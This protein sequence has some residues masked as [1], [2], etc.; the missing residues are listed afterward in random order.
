MSHVCSYYI[1]NGIKK[2]KIPSQYLK[3]I[4][5][6]GKEGVE[7]G[8]EWVSSDKCNAEAERGFSLVNITKIIPDLWWSYIPIIHCWGF[9][10]GASGQE[11][12]WQCRRYMRHG[13]DPWRGK[14]PWSRK[15]HPTP[16][17]LPEKF[18]GQRSLVGYS[19]WG[20]KESDVTERQST[21]THH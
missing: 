11:P 4:I 17:F 9:P 7:V 8:G 2:R 14:I 6:F 1:V 21:Q 16:I 18:H 3:T 20:R 10:S 19:P 5:W 15:W 12:A 13:F